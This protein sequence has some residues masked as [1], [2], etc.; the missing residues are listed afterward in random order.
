MVRFITNA[1]YGY[2]A[3]YGGLVLEK[4]VKDNRNRKFTKEIV[5]I[6]TNAKG[7]GQVEYA[8]YLAVDKELSL[9][10]NEF[11][12]EV[13]EMIANALGELQAELGYYVIKKTDI[14]SKDNG[15]LM[16][17]TITKLDD[18]TCIM[19]R[20]NIIDYINKLHEDVC[21]RLIEDKL[22]KK[23]DTEFN[24]CD[25]MKMNDLNLIMDIVSSIEDDNLSD[26]SLVATRKLVRCVE[27]IK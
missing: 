3:G 12:L 13:V 27:N 26:K 20:R 24:L 4:L 18:K 14:L 10:S 8:S 25:L 11:I 16:L 7:I 22:E 15:M 2:Q 1:D 17:D 9:F 5:K 19:I 23:D 6:I 21:L